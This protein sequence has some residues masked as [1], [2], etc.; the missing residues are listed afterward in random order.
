MIRWAAGIALVVQVLAPPQGWTACRIPFM[1]ASG[2]P[3]LR[4]TPGALGEALTKATEQLI[5]AV[6]C[7]NKELEDLELKLSTER[8][9]S[10]IA[11]SAIHGLRER[12]DA[13]ERRDPDR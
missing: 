5:D 10:S 13:L 12:L 7:L 2:P 9:R 1:S 11:E 8:L 6:N 4:G 3:I